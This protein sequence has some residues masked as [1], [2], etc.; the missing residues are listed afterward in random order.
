MRDEAP[1][2]LGAR[3]GIVPARGDGALV[4]TYRYRRRS[5]LVQ[6]AE[7]RPGRVPGNARRVSLTLSACKVGDADAA[8]KGKERVDKEKAKRQVKAKPKEKK[9]PK[10]K[11]IEQTSF[12]IANYDSFV[13]PLANASRGLDPRSNY[14]ALD[15]YPL[16][17]K[18][19]S[20]IVNNDAQPP[21]PPL[22]LKCGQLADREMTRYR[23]VRAVGFKK[24]FARAQRNHLAEM[25]SATKR[26][27]FSLWKNWMRASRGRRK[28]ADNLFRIKSRQFCKDVLTQW[29]AQ[30]RASQLAELRAKID[31]MSLQIN[32]AQRR[33]QLY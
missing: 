4:K 5:S 6:A 29:H 23:R 33:T 31:L 27:L 26:H 19:G 32:Q 7:G 17:S 3:L 15:H 9:E 28:Q 16:S 11:K 25:E 14:V 18:P 24:I 30:A 13:Q 10:K 2:V 1:S 12:D 20:S 21:P 8:K 22:C